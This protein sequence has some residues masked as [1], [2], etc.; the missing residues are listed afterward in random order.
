MNS[1]YAGYNGVKTFFVL[2][3]H[4]WIIQIIKLTLMLHKDNPS[5]Y[6]MQFW[7]NVLIY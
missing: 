2:F 4:T 7:N 3:C 1:R 5:K 6:K